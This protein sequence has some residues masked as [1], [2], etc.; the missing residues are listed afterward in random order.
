MILL[1]VIIKATL[2]ILCQASLSTLERTTYPHLPDD[3][4]TLIWAKCGE[5]GFAITTL[6]LLCKAFN[7]VATVASLEQLGTDHLQLAKKI[8]NAGH[9]VL[10]KN[11][12]FSLQSSDMFAA[13]SEIEKFKFILEVVRGP[14][15]LKSF[16]I[17]CEPFIPKFSFAQGEI[18]NSLSNEKFVPSQFAKTPEKAFIPLIAYFRSRPRLAEFVKL[19]V[20]R[21]KKR[22]MLS[23]FYATVMSEIELVRRRFVADD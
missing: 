9:R 10:I 20:E 15:D 11:L 22:D 18:V 8:Y 5:A 6:P 2:L 4:L 7:R 19:V 14:V 3:I 12:A 16:L 23:V 13:M 1:S 17:E 21:M